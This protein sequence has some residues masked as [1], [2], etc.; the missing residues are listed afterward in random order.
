MDAVLVALL[1]LAAGG[2]GA[3]AAS[4]RPRLAA[5]LGVGGCV[6]GCIVGLLAT[7][8]SLEDLPLAWRRP[9]RVPYGEIALEVDSLSALFL[10]VLFGLCLLAAIYGA[11]YLAQGGARRRQGPVWLFFNLLVASMALVV[12][13]RNAVLFLVAWEVMALSSFFLVTFEDDTSSVREAGRLYLIATH[14]GTAFLIALFMALAA[15]T[16]SAD[17]DYWRD[18][19]T[20]AAP[21]SAGLLFLLALVGFGTKAGLVPFHVWLPEAHPAAPSHVSAVMSGVMIKMGIYGLLRTFTFLGAPPPWWGAALLGLGIASAMVGVLF[22]LVQEDIKRL[23]AYS[24]VENVGLIAIG[25]GLGMIGRSYQLPALV[26]LGFTG[27]LLHVVNHALFKGVLFLG[28]GAIAHEAG[29]RQ[30][31]RLGGLLRKMPITG[32]CILAGSAAITALPPFNGFAGEFLL[33]LAS[34]G[35]VMSLQGAPGLLPLAALVGLAL[36]GALAGACFLRLS[37]LTLLGLPRAAVAQTARDPAAAMRLT[38]VVLAALCL[39]FGLAPGL[40]L[41]IVEP[42]AAVA[43]GGVT[44]HGPLEASADLAGRIPRIFVLLI[45]LVALLAWWRRRLLSHRDRSVALT[46]DC[47]YEQ[48]TPRMQYTASSFGEPIREMFAMLLPA[49]RHV[50]A[51]EGYFPSRASFRSE[52]VRPFQERLYGPA[53]GAVSRW[54]SRLRWLHHGRVQLYVLYIVV[55]LILMLSWFLVSQKVPR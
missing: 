20:R 1:L 41:R 54:I 39:L 31:D 36:S 25:L 10:L 30:I 26:A 15:G 48:P 28:A 14:A 19:A 23:L 13:A 53:F 27:A 29:T 51:P 35:G 32:A 5:G 38:M 43:S 24:S 42:A 12:M 47:G 3:L 21:A 40:P 50:V 22:A 6:A 34:F 7:A 18:A 16:G 55:T 8:S 52:V 49:R 4:S 11:A 17:F 33:Y 37:G 2:V 45:A 46:W 44:P 9:W